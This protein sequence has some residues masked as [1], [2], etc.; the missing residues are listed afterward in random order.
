MFVGGLH[1]GVAGA[2]LATVAAQLVSVVLCLRLIA[3]RM[4]QLQLQRADWAVDRREL[5]EPLRLG[6]SMGFQYSII[7]I[8]IMVL[9]WAINSLGA[10]TVA[11]FTAAARVDQLAVTPLASFGLALATYVAQNRGAQEWQRVRHG[12]ARTTWL[13]LGAAVV[14]GTIVMTVGTPIVRLFVGA[15]QDRVV[16]LAHHYLII[17][18]CLYGFLA[19]LF[20]YRNAVQGLGNAR[21]PMIS[22]IAE[23]VLRT[24]AALVLVRLIGFTGVALAPPLAWVAGSIP[25]VIS[26]VIARR[27]MLATEEQLRA[28]AKFIM[29]E[30]AQVPLGDGFEPGVLREP[31]SVPQV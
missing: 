19:I 9:Q 16:A 24:V 20:L 14:L 5:A 6:L 10:D 8:G 26:W 7:S 1:L 29:I 27:K 13:A 21:S 28:E 31:G 12:V 4:P 15:G 25:V 3:R 2:A 18:G 23:V 11:G 30:E 17:N 22:G